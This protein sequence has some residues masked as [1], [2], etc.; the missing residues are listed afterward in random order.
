[1]T[2]LFSCNPECQISDLGLP[3]W[4]V[5]ISLLL[6]VFF[7]VTYYRKW[8]FSDRGHA[9]TSIKWHLPKIIFVTICMAVVMFPPIWVTFGQIA[10]R[11]FAKEIF[12]WLVIG[13]YVIWLM[14]S[15]KT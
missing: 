2:D 9:E 13:V 12:P 4:T 15:D 10:G 1:M 6:S 14:S 11:V 7:L 3:E 5:V 8:A